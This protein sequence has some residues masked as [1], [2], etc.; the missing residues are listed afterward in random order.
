MSAAKHTPGEWIVKP[1]AVC[2]KDGAIDSCG[3]QVVAR[4][5]NGDEVGIF[6]SAVEGDD[7][8]DLHLIAAAPKLLEALQKAKNSLVAFKFMPGPGNAWE[9]SDEANL[10]A[11]DAA[12]AKATGAAA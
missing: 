3:T 10:N 9:D 12:I 8:A 2:D 4:L 11:V 1:W 7:L 6:S 5:P